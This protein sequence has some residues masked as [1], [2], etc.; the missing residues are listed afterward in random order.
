MGYYRRPDLAADLATQL[1]GRAMFGDAQNGLFLAAP[2]RTGKSM[3]L[4]HDLRPALEDNHVLVIYVDLWS[5]QRRDPGE[6]IAEGIALA[7]ADHQG[8]V[9]RAARKARLESVTIA[10]T[11]KIDT[12]KI[13]RPDGA[14]LPQALQALHRAAGKPVALLIDEAQHALTSEW[15]EAAMA[16]LKS[17]RDQMNTPDNV[18][19]MLV[20]SG[21]DRDKLLRLVN[22]AAAPFYGSSIHQMPTLGK[23]YV[24]Y[25]ADLIGTQRPDLMPVDHAALFQAFELF[26]QRP[27]F[28]HAAIGEAL[29]PLEAGDG[30][31]FEQ[32]VLAAARRRQAQD[33]AQMQSDFLGLKPLEQAVLWRMLAA[34]RAFRPYDAES[35]AFYRERCPELTVSPQKVQAALDSLR[36]R[37]P[38]LV[39]KSARGEY[40]VQDSAMHEWYQALAAQGGWPPPAA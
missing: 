8:V 2:R 23:R 37:T 9:A 34:G 13:G 24:D 27:Q 16:A 11:L 26:G 21:S 5:N 36:D 15:G 12:S 31:R 6:L 22:S 33:T 3:F 30:E 4:Q 19:L 10:G 20:M 7:L 29:N 1:Q 25:V 14:T 17:A 38:A 40:S 28:F 39:W 35:L 32:R 18:T